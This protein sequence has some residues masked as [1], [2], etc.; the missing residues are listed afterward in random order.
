MDLPIVTVFGGTGFLGRRVVRRLSEHAFVVRVATRRPARGRELFGLDDP[1]IESVAADV[2]DDQSVAAA[3]AGAYAAVNA[4]S[5]YVERGGT[6]FQGIHV[7]GARRVAVQARL[8]QVRRLAHVSGIGSN[9]AS[10][11]LYVR[12]R[13]EGELAVRNAFPAALIIRPAVM[14]GPDD[15][16]LSIIL[17]TLKV[18]PIYPM[19]GLGETRLQPADVEDVAEAIVR[20][21]QREELRAVTFDCGGPSVYSYKELLTTIAAE[22]G[23]RTLL[24]PLPFAAW[25]T[26][27]WLC[28]RLPNPPITTNQVDLMRFDNV[29]SGHAPGF[30]ELGITPHPLE[31]VLPGMIARRAMEHPAGAI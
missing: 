9:P 15:A 6:S 20:A 29:A 25:R 5:L 31:G 17:R 28:E 8:A 11:S 21:L 10:P 27:A 12:R 14:F 13:G 26:L 4:V 30:A 7:A 2:Q 23:R 22:A 18:L 24:V 1:H 19:F 3:V 16:F